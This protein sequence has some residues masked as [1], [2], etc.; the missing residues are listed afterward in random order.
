MVTDEDVMGAGY[1]DE[2]VDVFALHI[3][4]PC[5]HNDTGLWLEFGAEDGTS[6]RILS[7]YRQAQRPQGDGRVYGFDDAGSG[8][9]PH[10]QQMGRAFHG[11]AV[12]GG[13]RAAGWDGVG[14]KSALP[15]PQISPGRHINSAL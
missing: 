11:G 12:M 4:L 3:S 15:C 1:N 7:A 2:G 8:E 6:A 13:D 14:K 5:V 9:T 10:R